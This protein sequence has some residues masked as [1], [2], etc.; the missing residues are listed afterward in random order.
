MSF[1][2]FQAFLRS[3]HTLAGKIILPLYEKPWAVF[4]LPLREPE[5]LESGF[6]HSFTPYRLVFFA[7]R[8]DLE[9]GDGF[10]A[11][12]SAGGRR[13][14]SQPRR[15]LTFVSDTPSSG[16]LCLFFFFLPHKARPFSV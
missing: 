15:L 12:I 14:R 6:V 11:D 8:L 4:P 10:N 7:G 9:L 16:I 1:A 2:A 13:L 3:V 5:V